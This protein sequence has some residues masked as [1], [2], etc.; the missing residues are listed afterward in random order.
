MY[1]IDVRRNA[2]KELYSK[3]EEEEEQVHQSELQ[4]GSVF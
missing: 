1:I 2:K 4:K 3:T